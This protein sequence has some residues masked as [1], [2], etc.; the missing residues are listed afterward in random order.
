M[1]LLALW[2]L[3]GCGALK[4]ARVRLLALIAS[5]LP[6]KISVIVIKGE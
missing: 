6:D 4:G 1:L 2:P 3:L 5:L